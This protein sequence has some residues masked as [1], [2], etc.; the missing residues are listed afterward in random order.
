MIQQHYYKQGVFIQIPSG[1]WVVKSGVL[2]KQ[3]AKFN[4]AR[5]RDEFVALNIYCAGDYIIADSDLCFR[6][7]ALQDSS[8]CEVSISDIDTVKLFYQ[9]DQTEELIYINKKNGES[10]NGSLNRMHAFISWA[11]KK[12]GLPKYKVLSLLSQND[13]GDFISLTRGAVNRKMKALLTFKG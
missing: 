12:L 5:C 9:L 11:E 8:I 7:K 13:I 6:L 10:E 4:G 3:V 1:F 2:Q